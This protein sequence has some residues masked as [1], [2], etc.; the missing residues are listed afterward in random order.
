MIIIRKAF[1]RL[2]E[3]AEV[4]SDRMADIFG[5]PL[6]LLFNIT[7]WMFWILTG[8]E[9]FPYGELTMLLSMQAI[10]MS[11]LILNSATR[12]GHE[13]TELMQKDIR[14]SQG[15]WDTVDDIHDDIDDMHDDISDIHDD[16]EQIKSLLVDDEE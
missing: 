15:V 14:M 16:I 13:D 9:P 2:N 12:K 4:F 8:R 10:F 11:V 5:H 1:K 3:W 7:F 6:F